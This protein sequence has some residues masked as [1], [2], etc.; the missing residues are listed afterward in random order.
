VNDQSQTST[1]L[2]LIPQWLLN[3]GGFWESP[4][5]GYQAH[6]PVC[7][8]QTRGLKITWDGH[9][10]RFR[11]IDQGCHEA[12]ILRELDLGI[13]IWEPQDVEGDGLVS[14]D[15]LKVEH[16][17][18]IVDGLI[19]I[20]MLSV[21]A[22]EQGLGKSLL[23]ARWA[24]DLS[25][26]GSPSILVSAED[27]PTHTTKGR[28]MAAEANQTLIYHAQI[29]PTL[30]NGNGGAWMDQMRKWIE[31][32]GAQFLVLD[33]L[34]AFLDMQ[35]DSY[36]DQHMRVVLA[37]LDHVARET[38]CAIV[39]VM[40]LTKAAGSNPLQRIAGSVALTAAA[41]SVVLMAPELDPHH[42][43]RILAHVK[44]NVAEKATPQ[45]WEVKPI[46]IPNVSGRDMRTARIDYMGQA[47]VD[48]YTLLLPRVE[49]DEQG[50]LDQAK[51]IIEQQ[52]SMGPVPSSDLERA[53]REAGISPRTYDT[54]RRE[55]GVRAF[56]QGRRWYSDIVTSQ[57]AK[58]QDAIEPLRSDIPHDQED[59]IPF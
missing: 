13:E 42:P 4:T 58:V 34:S 27:S 18:W 17:E 33:P 14:F 49:S 39:Y 47:E 22:G 9:Q 45:R 54:A 36:K 59:G 46:V 10:W 24:A 37:A 35:A 52:V 31:K 1:R 25:R 44:C 50:A 23:H 7:G 41:R 5:G 48:V 30:G 11:C 43:E 12:E 40:H 6:C 29:L 56:Q 38:G 20:G 8:D 26:A 21:L 15:K 2:P 32:T 3:L 55:L 28:L 51:E 57:N 16:V 53:V 19:P